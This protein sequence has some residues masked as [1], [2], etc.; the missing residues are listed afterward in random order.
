M[1]VITESEYRRKAYYGW[2][3]KF[4]GGNIG[5]PY[6][7]I[8]NIDPPVRLVPSD[9]ASYAN[10]DADYQIAWFEVIKAR[11]EAVTGR[12]LAEYAEKNIWYPFGEY[13]YSM[14][15]IRRGIYPPVSGTFNN[16]YWGD[17]M[18]S[19]IRSELWAYLHPCQPRR[20]ASMA[21]M[22]SG[23]DHTAESTW[24]E[25]FLSAMQSACFSCGMVES[26]RLALACIP[27]D[28][29]TA[30]MVRDVMAWDE[31]GLRG[32]EMRRRIIGRYGHPD[33]TNSTQ[34]IAFTLAGMLACR[35][36]FMRTMEMLINFGYDTDCTCATAGATLGLLYAEGV[37]ADG[38]VEVLRDEFVLGID[39]ELEHRSIKR[40]AADVCDYAMAKGNLNA[41]DTPDLP[42]LG[43]RSGA[44]VEY[45]GAPVLTPGQPARIRVLDPAWELI[46]PEL[47]E[48]EVNQAA[49]HTVTLSPGAREV[50]DHYKLTFVSNGDQRQVGFA[51]PRKWLMKG[52]YFDC[53]EK[54]TDTLYPP[55]GDPG[56]DLPGILELFT[57]TA[58]VDSEYLAETELIAAIANGSAEYDEAFFDS[59][60]DTIPLDEHT[61]LEGP[62]C[63]YLWTYFRL[64]R[65]R[66]FW[67][68]AGNNAPF[69]LWVD[70]KE[71]IRDR[72]HR[73]WMPYNN[74]TLVDLSEGVHSL[75]IKAVKT[76]GSFEFSLAFKQFEERHYH[77]SHFLVG[78]KWLYRLD[79]A[80][81]TMHG[82]EQAKPDADMI[83]AHG[84]A[85]DQDGESA[86]AI[87]FP[88][89]GTP[90]V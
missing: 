45:L 39:I 26:I 50:R 87:G 31:D 70:G 52:P 75:A 20:A 17:G 73:P 37:L 15:N 25:A 35:G 54:Q 12:D 63:T 49:C 69:A 76:T 1:R 40:L 77:R 78:L 16:R 55:H 65:P 85:R 68:V 88:F 71:C 60:E 22:D 24:G 46:D 30:R 56:P 84:Q 82:R 48:L 72:E 6:E 36:D 41:A 38:L 62:L 44:I 34:N 86:S 3:G 42:Q 51:V 19:P 27:E 64:D 28:S 61:E 9:I 10:D 23:I 83:L 33:F 5:A 57:N 18:G 90:R 32:T 43:F 79:S 58:S 66:K 4:L 29:R 67:I 53:G 7:G 13:G 74:D 47:P 81:N 89:D 21:V 80:A 59:G 11:G 8:K 14:K 2:C